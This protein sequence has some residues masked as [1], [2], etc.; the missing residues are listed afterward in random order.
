MKRTLAIAL[1]LMASISTGFAEET[2]PAGTWETK[3]G[4][5]RYQVSMCGDGTELCAKLTW[6]RTDMRTAENLQYL[7]RFVIHGAKSIGQNKWRGKVDIYGE[8]A[9]GSITSINENKLKFTGCRAVL[10][11]TIEFNRL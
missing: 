9:T 5:S 7:N 11:Q 1:A 3:T 2:T 10:C 6:L 8:T 4:E